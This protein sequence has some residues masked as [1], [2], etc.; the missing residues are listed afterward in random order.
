MFL[1]ADEI[2]EV[3]NG[4]YPQDNNVISNSPHTIKQL[5]SDDWQNPYTKQK[6]AY[7]YNYDTV[8]KFW[9]PVSRINNAY[10]DRNLICSCSFQEEEIP[11]EKKCA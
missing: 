4:I 8:N 7:P 3:E 10:G 9:S 11:Q 2:T 5:I 1:I 6:A